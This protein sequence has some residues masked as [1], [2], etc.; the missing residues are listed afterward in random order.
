M[1]KKT[2]EDME[3]ELARLRSD[4]ED[5]S[6][7]QIS[8]QRAE[9]YEYYY[10]EPYGD[11]RPGRSD[12]VTRE[13]YDAVEWT[14]ADLMR[15]FCST[16]RIVEFS[17]QG[18]SDVP[19]AEQET[20]YINYVLMRKNPGFQIILDWIHDGLLQ[21]NGVVKW[22][23]DD[24]VNTTTETY[25]NLTLDEA[26]FLASQHPDME[27]EKF[28]AYEEVI[29][30]LLV[31]RGDATFRVLT[32]KPFARVENVPPEEFLVSRG[33][34]CIDTASYVAHRKKVTR[35]EVLEM[36]FSEK[37]IADIHFSGNGDN[38]VEFREERRARHANDDSYSYSLHGSGDPSQDTAWL[39]EEYY[40]TD[41]TGKGVAKLVKAFSIDGKVLEW[42]EAC[43]KPFSS[44]APLSL[45]HRYDGLSIHDV[46]KD[47]QKMKSSLTRSMLDNAQFANHSR[48]GV[49]EGQVNID[50]LLNSRPNGIVRMKSQ[51]ALQ[52]LK[53]SSLDPN[54]FS[55]LGY[56]DEMAEARS[57][58]SKTS[59]GLDPNALR[60]NVAASSVNAVMTAAMQK[61]DLMA[62][63]IAETGF[64]RLFYGLH[65]LIRRN[66]K[67]AD[68][69]K[70]RETYVSV[71]PTTWRDRTDLIVN[72]GLGN[73]NRD[74]QLNTYM[75]MTNLM[76][77]AGTQVP[78]L[79]SPTNAYKWLMKGFSL[80][81]YK[82][83]QNFVT[84]PATVEPAPEQPDPRIV[85]EQAR[86]QLEMA[87]LQEAQRHNMKQEELAEGE[88]VRKTMKDEDEIAIDRME[89]RIEKEQ[90]RP[91]GIGK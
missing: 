31:Q 4:A 55:V 11:E 50:D 43:E 5:W 39:Y 17:P 81:G 9:A 61:R 30:G 15:V 57:G 80:M 12:V 36:G 25:S 83:G 87:K 44:I 89:L 18:P 22:W 8:S 40:Y 29:D 46:L 10:G 27:L 52:E 14:K 53:S 24:T 84:D 49:L 45:P 79:I 73:G 13:V 68:Y 26:V 35:S 28:E 86:Q 48:Y 19:G 56:L 42:E 58:V 20:D 75:Q 21:K 62:R 60:S 51:G 54:T 47:I 59:Q 16:D 41:L 6:E 65:G 77:Q 69:V 33:A 38:E 7:S 34:R 67:Q 1:A 66:Q 3:V 70:L 82:D 76:I 91:V 71:D 23:W 85:I 63:T 88:L 90:G 78:D 74:A 2:V 64:K 37:Q 72:V 32:S